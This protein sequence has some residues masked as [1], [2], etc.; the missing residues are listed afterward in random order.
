MAR[1]KDDRLR[2]RAMPAKLDGSGV[3]K[4]QCSE[5]VYYALNLQFMPRPRDYGEMINGAHVV[6]ADTRSMGADAE[7]YRVIWPEY[8]NGPGSKLRSSSFTL[9]ARHT[10]ET[11]Y[12]LAEFLRTQGVDFVGLANRHGSRFKPAGLSG[13]KLAYLPG[14]RLHSVLA[15]CDLFVKPSPENSSS[16]GLQVHEPS[17]HGEAS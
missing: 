16:S 15:S 13:S 17:L 2:V 11:L 8:S 1:K 6:V 7:R 14:T 12:V 4:L 10:N 3:V 9:G 5:G